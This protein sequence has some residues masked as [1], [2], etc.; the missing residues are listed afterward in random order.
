MYILISTYKY[1]S[2]IQGKGENRAMKT[3][4]CLMAV[5]MAVM[6]ALSGAA[7]AASVTI[8]NFSFETPTLS[9]GAFTTGAISGWSYATGSNGGV[10]NPLLSDY[11]VPMPDGNNV[12]YVLTTPTTIYQTTGAA[13]T[14]NY[15]YTLKAFVGSDRGAL[16]TYTI[17]LVGAGSPDVVLASATGQPVTD[18]FTQVTVSYL[19]NNPSQY[20]KPI[21]I[22][23]KTTDLRTHFDKVT[24][25]AS[26]VPT[27][28]TWFLLGSGLLG[29]AFLGRR[30]TASKN[31]PDRMGKD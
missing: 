18:A 5:G 17:E 8:N 25:D 16:P 3:R 2:L 26:P 27:P 1:P 9:D 23:L 10:W 21:K 14:A 7:W 15:T 19:G 29:L 22:N 31:T 30:R 12:A 6:L 4:V 13:V 11:P 28:A 24:L 20:G